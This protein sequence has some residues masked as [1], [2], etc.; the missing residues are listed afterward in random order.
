MAYSIYEVNEAQDIPKPAEVT[1]PDYYLQDVF[2]IDR[3]IVYNPNNQPSGEGDPFYKNRLINDPQDYNFDDF[4]YNTSPEN[5]GNQ[6]SNFV[7]NYNI[8]KIISDYR[9]ANYPQHLDFN[10]FNENQVKVA[11][12]ITE[13]MR[14]TS[15]F[16]RKNSPRCN[17][18]LLEVDKKENKWTYNVKC[19]E[20]NSDPHGHVVN[21]ALEKDPRE[22]DVRRV[23]VK[24]SCSCEFWKYWGPDF[25]ANQYKYLEGPQRSDGSSPNVRDPYRKNKVCKHVYSVGMLFVKFIKNK[26]LDVYKDV[27]TIFEN[28]DKLP[29]QDQLEKIKD[30][31]DKFLNRSDKLEI[32]P[33]IK[34]VDKSKNE[35]DFDRLILPLKEKFKD[36][37]DTEDK[38]TI[39]KVKNQVLKKLVK[40]EKEPSPFEII[41]DIKIPKEVNPKKEDEILD[42]LENLPQK[43]KKK[44]EPYIDLLDDA[45]P[46]EKSGIFDKIL[47]YIRKFFNIKQKKSS[48]VDRVLNM[49]LRD[50]GD[51]ND[52]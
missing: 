23:D 31:Q 13:L 32:S 33:L 11:V 35:K 46:K 21:I 42:K 1:S 36:I 34:K 19:Y 15:N 4:Q 3:P 44:I 28:L 22:T 7:G 26:N 2:N 20:K 49:Y 41:K 47:K 8:N 38:A 39:L 48:S 17:V 18:S 10:S 50:Q 9:L 45:T 43:D 14:A 52:L 51:N 12:S 6:G 27:D 16:S 30:I 29:P 37:L 24:V 25:N 5:W 40:P